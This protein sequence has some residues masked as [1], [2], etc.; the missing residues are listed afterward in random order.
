V[1]NG[2]EEIVTSNGLASGAVVS[3]GGEQIIAG[4]A[5]GTT[6]LSGGVAIV[7]G[8]ASA[9]VV[10]D[11]GTME[12]SSGGVVDSTTVGSGGTLVV[13][14]GGLDGGPDAVLTDTGMY[15]T[16]STTVSSGGEEI[17]LGFSSAVTIDS[18]GLVVVSSGGAAGASLVNSG[19]VEVISSGG[20]VIRPFVSSGGE[21][22]VSAG[23][24]LLG[25]HLGSD[26]SYGGP[27]VLG[28]TVIVESGGTTN[29]D[30]LASG[31]R[32]VI[33]SGGHAAQDI[34]LLGGTL[35]VASGGLA[36]YVEFDAI[37][38]YVQYNVSGGSTLVLDAATSFHGVVAGFGNNSDPDKIDRADIAFG[39]AGK[40][41][42]LSYNGNLLGG[43]L[44]VTDG[45][46][47]A[48]IALLGQYIASEF[49]VSNDGHGG[50]LITFTADTT[51]I[52]TGGGGHHKV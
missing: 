10:L 51:P 40:K 13:L 3:G 4:R 30:E 50:T 37:S 2:G 45:V 17:V 33:L 16:D 43:T 18:G 22:V 5:I 19:G 6:V 39:T 41:G 1:L 44:T 12:V 31:S 47:T 27:T 23:G 49:A 14:Q 25:A 38:S 24:T 20:E 46:H 34:S 42:P 48:N 26:T 36:N 7:A 8:V 52:A 29:G 32:E 28:G 11:G 15:P 21:V 35:E 9:A